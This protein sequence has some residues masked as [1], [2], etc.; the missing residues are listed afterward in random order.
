[1]PILAKKEVSK[2]VSIGFK[3]KFYFNYLAIIYSVAQNNEKIQV[4]YILN[5]LSPER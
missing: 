5:A 4:F 1:M 2:G 3:V